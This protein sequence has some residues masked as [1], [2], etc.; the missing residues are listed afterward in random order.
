MASAN[1]EIAVD[2]FAVEDIISLAQSDI[3]ASGLVSFDVKAAGTA[4]DPTF[5]GSFGTQHFFYNGTLIPEVHGTLSYA[6]QTLTGRADAMREGE[7]SL[8]LRRRDDSRSTS[9]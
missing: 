9:R 1:L 5:A 6:N 3:D 2:N 4:A 8:L 7:Q